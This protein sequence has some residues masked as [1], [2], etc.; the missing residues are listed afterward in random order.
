MFVVWWPEIRR[1]YRS[2]F[3][4]EKR[5]R[6]LDGDRY[7]GTREQPRRWWWIITK[8][9]KKRERTRKGS[10]WQVFKH[11]F[12]DVIYLHPQTLS[13]SIDSLVLPSIRVIAL[14]SKKKQPPQTK[15]FPSPFLL[16]PF[17]RQCRLTSR[18]SLPSA[19]LFSTTTL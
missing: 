6:K 3:R 14:S 16:S 9:K 7:T 15:Q 5:A 13:A 19:I 1:K 12:L 17:N 4:C 11:H 8:K 18:C 10:S 2:E